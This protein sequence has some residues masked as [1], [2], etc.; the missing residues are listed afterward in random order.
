MSKGTGLEKSES[1]IEQTEQDPKAFFLII[2]KVHYLFPLHI[3]E[4]SLVTLGGKEHSEKAKKSLEKN[5]PTLSLSLD[6]KPGFRVGRGQ[7]LPQSPILT[8][9]VWASDT[10]HG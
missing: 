5:P 8:E 6:T 10:G 1:K 9:L 7:T 3:R 2:I 4:R